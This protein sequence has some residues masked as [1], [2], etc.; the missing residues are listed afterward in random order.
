[1]TRARRTTGAQRDMTRAQFKAALT[2]NGFSGPVFAWFED[3]TGRTP[4]ISYSGVFLSDG[5][6]CRRATIAYLIKQR[7]AEAARRPA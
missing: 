3:T 5:T 1:M 7:D 6:L 4:G 2:R